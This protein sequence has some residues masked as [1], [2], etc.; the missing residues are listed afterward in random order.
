MA[1]NDSTLADEYDV[2]RAWRVAY[3]IEALGSEDSEATRRSSSAYL[4]RQLADGVVWVAV[5]NERPI[6]LSSFNAALPDI[7]QLGGIY[8]PPELRD[9]GYA[10]V[11][12]A[13]SL[14]DASVRGVTRAVL[15][16]NNPSAARSYEGVG[17]R[18]VGDYGLVL[19]E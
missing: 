18:R 6:S 12:V 15:F 14:L 9:R 13:G 11:A 10:K 16:T 4:E 5:A 7:V 17:F 8:T 3:D 19:F 2:L 1:L